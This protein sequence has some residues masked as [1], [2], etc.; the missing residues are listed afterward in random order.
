MIY[1]LFLQECLTMCVYNISFTC[2][3]LSLSPRQRNYYADQARIPYESLRDAG[4]VHMAY[5]SQ[6]SF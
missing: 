5:N 3:R 2:F 1:S 6:L 4:L